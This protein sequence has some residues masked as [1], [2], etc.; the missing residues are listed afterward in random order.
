MENSTHRRIAGTVAVLTAL[1]CENAAIVDRLVRRSTLFTPLG[2]AYTD[3][4]FMR[5]DHEIVR[6]VVAQIG[7]GNPGAAL[8]AGDAIN[9]ITPDMICFVGIA[10]GLKDVQLG[11]VVVATQ[12][13]GYERGK[14]TSRGFVPSPQ[15]ATSN[16][17][18]VALCRQ[19]AAHGRWRQRIPRP[20]RLFEK[21]CKV[22]IAPI[23]AGEK[24]IKSSASAITR[25]IRRY[26]P[27][28][29][30]V[31]M[32]GFGTLAAAAHRDNTPAIV[33]RGISD[34]LVDKDTK[35]DT[36]W[37]PRAAATA[38]AVFYELLAD[39]DF[40]WLSG[41]SREPFNARA[42]A[43]EL[44]RLAV[45]SL[46]R[47]FSEVDQWAGVTILRSIPRSVASDIALDIVESLGDGLATTYTDVSEVEPRSRSGLDPAPSIRQVT[48]VPG[49][50][51]R[52][53]VFRAVRH[54]G[55]LRFGH[56][57]VKVWP[58]RAIRA[59]TE[60]LDACMSVDTPFA[61]RPFSVEKVGQ[62]FPTSGVAL[63]SPWY[64][65]LSLH[66][67]AVENNSRPLPLAEGK[68]LWQCLCQVVCQL[69]DHGLLHG[70]IKPANVICQPSGWYTLIDFG[71]AG[72]PGP[73]DKAVGTLRY[74]APEI[75]TGQR[76]PLSD[77]YSMAL[78]VGD[79]V[80]GSMLHFASRTVFP[81]GY[82]YPE[83][84]STFARRNFP[85]TH[86]EIPSQWRDLLQAC[87][88]DAH[89]RPEPHSLVLLIDELP[90]T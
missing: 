73:M 36:E 89:G 31:E 67:W 26:F 83:T 79:A 1:P 17:R 42:L 12:V 29:V 8:A 19:I 32:E 28:A 51:V 65:D 52:P 9:E 77:V 85:E 48:I 70:D 14:A 13:H 87:L 45:T 80:Y 69:F 33:I 63:I 71:S 75:F 22:I 66:S 37:Q 4:L 82:H 58:E 34:L 59:L 53:R 84:V 78:T 54:I 49:R 74:M 55:D 50:S 57:S 90:I 86:T 76:H 41:Q 11:D 44:S 24:V 60:E 68:L 30:A 88:G 39:L 25:D 56:V 16:G 5:A 21:D 72:R 18:L 81:D 6:V 10:G 40:E 38:S 27:D 61:A 35:H 7:A 62:P 47:D 3:G 43:P 46:A 15:A 20:H 23:A 64:G 2:G